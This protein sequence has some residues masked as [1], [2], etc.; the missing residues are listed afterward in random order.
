VL[1]Q[2][3]ASVDA[4]GTRFICLNRSTQA[5]AHSQPCTTLSAEAE[6][7]CVERFH[8]QDPRIPA[9]LTRAPGQ[10]LYCQDHF[11]DAEAAAHI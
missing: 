1:S 7:K 5:L 11:A 2:V 4:L 8:A 3:T 6:R 10:W 9:L